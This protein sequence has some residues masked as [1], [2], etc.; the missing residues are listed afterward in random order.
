MQREP[1]CWK[2]H[3]SSH[4][5]STSSLAARRRSFFICPLGFGVG[6]GNNRARFPA[7]KPQLA[8][9]TLALPNSELNAV[10]L[11]QVVTEEFSVPKILGIP[12]LPRRQTQIASNLLDGFLVH[13]AWTPRAETFLQTGKAT[14]FESFNP[15]LNRA[16]A[17][18]QHLRDFRTTESR[19]NKQNSVQPVVITGFLGPSDFFLDRESDK[20]RIFDFQFAH[21]DSPPIPIGRIP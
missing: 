21:D 7:T 19:T 15:V 6:L 2:W 13:G 9:Q 12:Q 18:P 3:S 17:L 1:C 8:K 14:L 4:H 16:A 10:T 5:T 20:L 11:R